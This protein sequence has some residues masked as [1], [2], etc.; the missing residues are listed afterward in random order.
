MRRSFPLGR[1]SAPDAPRP[2]VAGIPLAML[3]LVLLV[4]APGEANAAAVRHSATTLGAM[5]VFVA[6]LVMRE[7]PVGITGSLWAVGTL[8]AAALWFTRAHFRPAWFVVGVDRRV[9]DESDVALGS[10]ALVVSPSPAAVL[11]SA[12]R[13]FIELQ[14]AWDAGDVERMRAHTATEMLDE[15][16][17]ELPNRGSGTNR[18]DILTLHA[19]LLVLECVGTRLVASVEFSGMI[20]ESVDDGAKPFREVWMLMCLDAAEPQ[21]RLARQQAL[22]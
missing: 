4:S 20:R 2:F 5:A 17:Q 7:W 8:F 21:W 22:M 16:L 11:A 3:L 14:S 12:R 13:C 18:T 6:L 15:L 1:R 9:Q 10:R 19:S